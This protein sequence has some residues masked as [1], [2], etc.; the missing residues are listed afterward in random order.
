M[1]LKLEQY[2]QKIKRTL[3]YE[4]VL[5]EVKGYL[6]ANF[7]KTLVNTIDDANSKDKIIEIIDKYIN[8]NGI[9]ADG[10]DSPEQLVNRLYNDMSQFGIITKYITDDNVEEIN[11]NAYNDIEVVSPEGYQKLDKTYKTPEQLQDYAKKIMNIGGITLDES[12]PIGDGYIYVGVRASAIISPCVDDDIGAAISIRRQRVANITKE[13]YVNGGSA[14]PDEIDM[15]ADFVKYGVSVAFTGATESGKT[16]DMVYFLKQIP[17]D[18]RI[19]VMEEDT[20]EINLFKYD[21][22]GRIINRVIHTK[23][24]KS[25]DPRKNIDMHRLS[26]AGLRFNPYCIVP[27]EMRAGEAIDALE[28]ARTGHVVVTGFH[29]EEAIEGYS[30]ILTM[31][32]MSDTKLSENILLDMIVKAFPIMVF[33]RKLPDRTRRFM[34]IFE[35]EGQTN[36]IVRGRYLYRFIVEDNIY[37]NDKVTVVGH[38]QKEQPISNKLAKKMLDGGAPLSL[39]K[40]YAGS[41]WKPC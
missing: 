9:K 3:S 5:L 12:Q 17:N 31:C 28:A 21:T 26:L 4:S 15:I 38:H 8:D 7:A 10:T 27:A 30:R 16:T 40:K 32:C 41:D 13:Q 37:D 1:E 20:R 25:D 36:G 33:K 14:L 11:C 24:S 23:T 34:E 19:Y 22:T 18:K 35:A 6:T 39:V 2:R 29:S